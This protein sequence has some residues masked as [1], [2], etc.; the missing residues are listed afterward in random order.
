[1]TGKSTKN[2]QRIRY[3]PKNGVGFTYQ[4]PPGTTKQQAKAKKAELLRQYKLGNI[5]TRGGTLSEFF[6]VF[7]VRNKGR[8]F[9]TV[10]KQIREFERHI[11]PYFG[12]WKL[13]DIRPK[14]L[15]TW[16]DAVCKTL[17]PNSFKNVR[18]HFNAIMKAAV[19]DE[20]VITNPWSGIKGVKIEQPAWAFWDKEQTSRFLSHA[21]NHDYQVF[22]VIAFAIYTGLRPGE[23][24]A[25]L[26]RD[27][28]WAAGTV[29]VN[30]TW[31][32]K[33]N[34]LKNRTKTGKP[35]SVPIPRMVLEAIGNLRGLDGEAQL[36]PFLWN[37]WGF[38]RFQPLAEK[39]GVPPIK[40]HECRHSFASQCIMA[41]MSMVEVK[42]LM[43]HEKIATTIDTYTHIAE[44][45]KVRSTDRL[46]EGAQWGNSGKVRNLRVG[47]AE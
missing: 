1:M 29:W 41:G 25:V 12:E 32:T 16:Q 38:K 11:E 45:H 33:T 15:Q 36:F 46:T 22:Q 23:L 5:E 42:E 40:L 9:S 37:S 47:V 19:A 4:L 6:E 3:R 44:R 8:Q 39:A 24:R 10:K 18:S 26:R 30:R 28:D 31:C 20:R 2:Y 17:S 43:G 27:I 14:D 35:R 7:L 21:R 13:Q 34:S